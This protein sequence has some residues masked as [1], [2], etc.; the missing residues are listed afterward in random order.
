M[1]LFSKIS[2][3]ANIRD[4]FSLRILIFETRITRKVYNFISLYASQNQSLEEFETFADN[5]ELNLDAISKNNPFVSVL[6]GDLNA[7]LINWYKNDSTS[8]EVTKID[9][10]QFGMQQFIS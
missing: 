7:K 2:A 4:S 5:L 3:F 9:R 6:L 1:Y 10:P 8:Y